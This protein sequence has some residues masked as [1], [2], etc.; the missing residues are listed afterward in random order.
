MPALV[1][2]GFTDPSLSDWKKMKSQSSS[3]HISLRARD[4]EFFFQVYWQ[5][6]FCVENSLFSSM[7]YFKIGL[8]AFLM[9]S[10]L[11]Y[12]YILDPNPLS[13]V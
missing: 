11:S 7:T 2:I 4:G 13:D 6:L 5:F 10:V 8:L 3:N 12:V 9:L 1:T